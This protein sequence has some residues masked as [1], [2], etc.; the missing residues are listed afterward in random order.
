MGERFE[1]WEQGIGRGIM[2]RG[3]GEIRRRMLL[4]GGEAT[5]RSNHTKRSGEPHFSGTH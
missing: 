3:R 5:E 4:S 2:M 1:D